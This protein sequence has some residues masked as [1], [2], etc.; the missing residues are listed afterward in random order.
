MTTETMHHIIYA[1]VE[2]TQGTQRVWIHTRGTSGA[3][4]S[5]GFLVSWCHGPMALGV[6]VRHLVLI[7]WC[8]QRWHSCVSSCT[9]APFLLARILLLVL[10]LG[11]VCSLSDQ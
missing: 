6:I 2:G 1:S 9:H 5:N 8:H 7:K 10:L 3:I 11:K 4:L